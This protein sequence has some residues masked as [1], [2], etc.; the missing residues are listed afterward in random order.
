[1][2]HLT[3]SLEL[4]FLYIRALTFCEAPSAV[5]IFRL[6]RIL[7]PSVETVEPLERISLN[8]LQRPPRPHVK[9]PQFQYC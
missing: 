9:S 4:G 7:S 8:L 1:M 2:W 6:I 5:Y 3:C